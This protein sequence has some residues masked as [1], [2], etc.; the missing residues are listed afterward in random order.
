MGKINVQEEKEEH[1]SMFERHVVHAWFGGVLQNIFKNMRKNILLRGRKRMGMQQTLWL[2]V[3]SACLNKESRTSE[4]H[5]SCRGR[6]TEPRNVWNI[7]TCHRAPASH[8]LLVGKQYCKLR[9]THTLTGPCIPMSWS[10]QINATDDAM[11][12]VLFI[13]ALFYNGITKKPWKLTCSL[14]TRSSY[15]TKQSTL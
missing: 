12:Q 5:G 3:S 2:A 1:C 9:H 11:S 10:Y 8:Y 15:V 7:N 6:S 14:I 4:E 13:S